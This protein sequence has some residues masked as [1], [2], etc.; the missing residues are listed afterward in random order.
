MYRPFV[1]AMITFIVSSCAVNYPS[2]QPLA[3]RIQISPIYP[4]YWEY[5]GKPVLLLGASDS[6]ALF[7]LPD[8]MLPNLET[9]HAIGG[10]YIRSTLS[11]RNEGN[12]FPFL[13]Q[14][15]VF[16]LDQLNPEFFAR[17][18]QSIREAEQRDIIVQ[19][20]FWDAHDVYSRKWP[21]SPWNPKNNI[22]YTADDTQLW[23]K[24]K[25]HHT[26]KI[27][28]FF[29]TVPVLHNDTK[30]LRYQEA[31]IRK[32]LEVT[33]PY[34]NV[35]YCIG[36]ESRAPIEW[37]HYWGRFIHATASEHGVQAQVTAMWNDRLLSDPRHRR[38]YRH[39]DIFSFV[40]VSQNNWHRGQRHYDLLQ[41]MRNNLSHEVGGVRP[42]NN[43]KVYAQKGRPDD[44]TATA[45]IP[46]TLDR[47][48]QN[49]FA[50]CA[51]TRFHR[52]EYVEKPDGT[53]KQNYGL[54]L[55][56][57]AQQHIRSARL[58]TDAF[59]IFNCE[60]MPELLEECGDNEAYCL[61]DLQ[62][63]YAVYFPT[64]GS[65]ELLAKSNDYQLRWF[66]IETATFH[67]PVRISRKEY[68]NPTA[69]QYPAH[70]EFGG[71]NMLIP[72]DTPTKDKLWLALLQS[73]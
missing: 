58:F 65:I 6:D 38:T 68:P 44:P 61:A 48:W 21:V 1:I 3:G 49:I 40:E 33:L 11:S 43:V 15:G 20:E 23:L 53:I 13:Q 72:L 46:L 36:N 5:K 52:A 67:D 63:T 62:Y 8:I 17:L 47:W 34:P 60:P 55:A 19:I 45:D 51:S 57:I 26:Q 41:W 50:G 10:N 59:N 35:L 54:G 70:E 71:H 14:D 16:D 32:A 27:Q 12:V 28:P 29:K 22:N 25:K 31:F 37:A 9:L 69:T 4:H 73:E 39:P 30:V 42:M 2:E 24:V 66:D 18:E 7:N 56:E 64:G